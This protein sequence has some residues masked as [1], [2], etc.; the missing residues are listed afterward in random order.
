V[1]TP[2][3]ILQ[4]SSNIC[5]A[6]VGQKLG[7][8]RLTE[9]FRNFGFGERFGLGLPGEGKGSLPYP[10]AEIALAT[11]SF[12]QGLSA[13]SL[14]IAAAYATLAN[15]GVLMKPFLVS[16]V[17]D[18]DGLVLL[19]NKPTPLRRVVS[20]QVAK[21]VVSMLETVVEKGGTATKARLEEYRVAGKT[22]TAQKVDPIAGGY[23]DRR[24]SSFAGIVPAEDPRAVIL[25]V[26]DEPSVDRYGGDCAAPAFKEI[27]TQLMPHVGAPKSREMPTPIAAIEKPSAKKPEK[28]VVTAGIEKLEQM[29][30]VTEEVIAEG[31][32]RVPNLKGLA[33]RAAVAQLLTAALEPHLAG[34]GRVVSQKPAAG[35]LVEKGTRITVE[36]A[37]Q[38][39]ASPR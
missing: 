8:E 9:T 23:S 32:V 36:L 26:I 38:L 12:G 31:A 35:S 4:V 11:Q 25:V 20:P 6:K 17:V 10:K 29:D 16:K 28:S 30:T 14:Q 2:R 34:S 33:G 21:S 19:E 24:L 13:T 22:G 27:A 3:G 39:P 7:R 18:A 37:G 1:L 15:E 5:A